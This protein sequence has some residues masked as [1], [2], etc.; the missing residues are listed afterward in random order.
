MKTVCLHDRG[1]IEA[2][3]RRNVY[4]HLYGIGDLDD[5]YWPHTTWYALVDG[6]EV[7]AMAL[8]YSGVPEPTL[9]ALGEDEKIPFLRE[10]LSS[11]VGLLPRH[12]YGHLSA[13]LS[14]VLAE[15][16][17]VISYGEHFKM[18]LVDPDAV[19]GIDSPDVV[20]LSSGD[21]E[22]LLAF[23]AESYPNHSFE[24]CM[25]ETNRYYGV[26]GPGGLI[27]AAGVHV[28]SERYS[29]AA[30]A[31]VATHPEHRRRGLGR[32][33]VSELCGNL[34]RTVDHVGLNV[35]AANT[36]AVDFYESLGFRAVAS[37]EECQMVSGCSSG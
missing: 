11:I 12:F 21:A 7:K 33:V 20:E 3:L 14:S 15:H 2:F 17:K 25:L 23:Y 8:M 30:L 16:Y 37:Y 36:A 34:L 5:H 31:N 10:L 4:L 18:A 22:A 35:K 13:P 29:V 24:P 32:A 6:E 28:Y 9:L 26:R 1:R 27:S 19:T